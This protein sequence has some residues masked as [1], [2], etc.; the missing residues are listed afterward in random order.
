MTKPLTEYTADEVKAAV[1]DRYGQVAAT[2]GHKFNFPVGRAFAESVG[3]DATIL[4]QLP[5]SLWES[6]TGAGNPQPFVDAQAGE[7]VLDLGCGRQ[8][9]RIDAALAAMGRG[10]GEKPWCTGIHLSLA[11]IAVGCAVGYLDFR[12]PQIDWRS[13]HPNLAKLATKLSTRQSFIDTAP[14]A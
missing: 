1:A 8:M 3:Y 6:F 5:H 9:V 14:A 7:T 4:D 11:D 10:L 12:F 2:P 13:R